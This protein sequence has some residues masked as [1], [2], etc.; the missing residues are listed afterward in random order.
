MLC[1]G[2]SRGDEEVSLSLLPLRKER[3]GWGGGSPP[4]RACRGGSSEKRREELYVSGHFTV[5]LCVHLNPT[6]SDVP[7]DQG[8]RRYSSPKVPFKI[9]G[10]I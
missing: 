6:T 9:P 1:L 10:F 2:D 5:F 4:W 3:A 7:P 8:F